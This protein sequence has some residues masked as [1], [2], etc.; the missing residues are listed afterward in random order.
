MNVGKMEFVVNITWLSKQKYEN[1][2]SDLQIF[3]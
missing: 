2:N 3:K 1:L